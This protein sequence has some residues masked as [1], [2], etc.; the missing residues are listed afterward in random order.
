LTSAS[1]EVTI[2]GAMAPPI[3]SPRRLTQL[4]V[5]AVPKSMT[6]SG[7]PYFADAANA[8]TYR[9]APT[10][11]GASTARGIRVFSPGSTKNGG[12]LKYF[13]HIHSSVCCT[14]GTTLEI[15]TVDARRAGPETGACPMKSL[16]RKNC[17]PAREP[18]RATGAPVN[19]PILVL[20]LLTSATSS[21][22]RLLGF[23]SAARGTGVPAASLEPRLRPTRRPTARR[24]Q[25]AIDVEVGRGPGD[26]I[27]RDPTPERVS[28]RRRHPS[29]TGPKPSLRAV[30]ARRRSLEEGRE[31]GL[32]PGACPASSATD[33]AVRQIH[34]ASRWPRL[35]PTPLSSRSRARRAPAAGGYAPAF[36]KIP[37]IFRPDTRTSFGHFGR[38]ST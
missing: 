16:Y 4:N 9:S 17:S 30:P 23:L 37:A 26:A 32:R 33:V 10:S 7:W 21:M 22:P 8:S 5:V 29:R 14:G 3:T 20:V 24:E 36:G 25:R 34:R 18:P 31:H 2:P 11:R 15:D 13:S 19:T 27:D 38:A 28:P 1:T 35:M 12:R 6:I